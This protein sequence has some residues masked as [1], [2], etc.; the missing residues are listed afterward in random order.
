MSS[1][2][3]YENYTPTLPPLSWKM[4]KI[5]GRRHG[6]MGQ[7]QAI[8][9]RRVRSYKRDTKTTSGLLSLHKW[10]IEVWD[11]PKYSINNEFDAKYV[12]CELLPRFMPLSWI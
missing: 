1:E 8:E 12:P 9:K 4:V 6:M 10:S 7:S 11:G 2:T 5:D 3:R